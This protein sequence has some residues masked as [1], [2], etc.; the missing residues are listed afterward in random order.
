MTEIMPSDLAVVKAWIDERDF[1]TAGQALVSYLSDNPDDEHGL[2]LMGRLLLEQD[3]PA[4]ARLVYQHT[5][6]R[7]GAKR[8]Q[9]WLNLGKALDHLNRP[10]DAESCYRKAL[11]L[12]PDNIAVLPALATCLVQQYR[13]EE[14]IEFCK[15]SL[16]LN[17]AGGQARST[18]GFAHIQMRQWREGW[19]C[20][21]AGYG[22]LRWRNERIYVGEGRWDGSKH[23]GCHVIVHGEQGI[24]DQIA[25][26]EP[27][28]DMAEATTVLALEVNQKIHGL[29]QRSFPELDVYGTL[30]QKDLDWPHRYSGKVDA[31]CGLFSMHRHFRHAEGD[32]SG[33]P[34]LAADPQRRI[35]WRALLDSLGPEPKVG[36]AWSGGVSLTQRSARRADLASWLPILKQDCHWVSLEYRDRSGELE[37]LKRQRGIVVHDWPWAT[38]TDDYDDTAALVAEL[39]AVIC[40][41]TSIVHLAGALG[42]PVLCMTHPRPNLH[43]CGRGET[44]AYYGDTVRLFRRQSNDDWKPSIRAVANTI[45]GLCRLTVE[46]NESA[47]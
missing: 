41:P 45:S 25:G 37:K 10:E 9:D 24:G 36:L 12:D 40:V 47:A 30:G 13:S 14:S 29:V 32:Y 2:F 26:L 46:D 38:R 44:I 23:K 6:A 34:Y 31:H 5:T 15:R 39:D 19:E 18:M 33:R 27:M 7:G 17:P 1:V 11:K 42:T 22:R 28:A 8:W 43:Y 35:Q 3:N 16:E 20:Y 21:E 4:L